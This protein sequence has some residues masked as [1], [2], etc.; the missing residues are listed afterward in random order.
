MNRSL[1]FARLTEAFPMLRS[2][3]VNIRAVATAVDDVAASINDRCWACR[4][5]EG[6]RNEP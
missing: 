3:L 1:L 6:D 4:I 5:A 2:E